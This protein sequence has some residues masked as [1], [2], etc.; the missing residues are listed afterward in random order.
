MVREKQ[1]WAKML[2][3]AMNLGTSVAAAIAVGLFGGRWLDDRLNTGYLFTIIGFALGAA[4][5]GKMLWER[6]MVDTVK[7]SKK[8]F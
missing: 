3:V 1:N 7:A 2:A 8:K 4:T 6:L 5:A